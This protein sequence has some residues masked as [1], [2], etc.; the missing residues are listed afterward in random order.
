MILFQPAATN[1]GLF[2]AMKSA[3]DKTIFG[4]C[5][6]KTV[7]IATLILFFFN[8]AGYSQPTPGEDVPPVPG[9]TAVD[10]GNTDSTATVIASTKATYLKMVDAYQR[11]LHETNRS[12]Q[13]SAVSQLGLLAAV[14]DPTNVTGTF[15]EVRDRATMTLLRCC[16]QNFSRDSSGPSTPVI[17]YQAAD[18]LYNA[19]AQTGPILANWLAANATVAIVF[20]FPEPDSKSAQAFTIVDEIL[21]V[22]IL[23]TVTEAAIDSKGTFVLPPQALNNVLVSHARASQASSVLVR[24]SAITNLDWLSSRVKLQSK[25]YEFLNQLLNTYLADPSICLVTLK[26]LQAQAAVIPDNVVE[27][28]E[29]YISLLNL[30]DLAE[31]QPIKTATLNALRTLQT[32]LSG[33]A[34][35]ATSGLAVGNT[36][37]TNGSTNTSASASNTPSSNGNTSAGTGSTVP[38]FVSTDVDT[39]ARESMPFVTAAQS[40]AV[41]PSPRVRPAELRVK[42]GTVPVIPQN[43][44]AGLRT[45]ASTSALGPVGAQ[46][47]F[48]PVPANQYGATGAARP[49][50]GPSR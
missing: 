3:L 30:P 32:A 22:R 28:S 10:T 50:N 43:Q 48:G 21:I 26:V 7:T 9:N 34:T 6:M 35:A 4:G 17:A 33:S 14:Q 12:I 31:H 45:A 16:E 41:G 25:D 49:A 23:Q 27:L 46:R 20:S 8:P 36:G 24:K 1:Q 40:A 5:S 13:K 38:F 47:A 42:T 39:V 15:Q 11:L 19:R 37:T 44:L 2:G 29:T 18:Q